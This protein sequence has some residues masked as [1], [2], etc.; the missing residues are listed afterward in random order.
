[1]RIL[2][3]RTSGYESQKLIDRSER[4]L[5]LDDFSLA[6]GFGVNAFSNEASHDV[7]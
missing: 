7:S 3:N 2:E 5:K 1:M 4:E 6:R